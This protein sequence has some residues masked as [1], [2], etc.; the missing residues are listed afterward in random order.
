MAVGTKPNTSPGTSINGHENETVFGSVS[1][2]MKACSNHKVKP[3][4]PALPLSRQGSRRRSGLIG[5][6]FWSS[7][8]VAGY[9]GLIDRGLSYSRKQVQTV[10]KAVVCLEAG[11]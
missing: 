9:R 1:T 10:A 5:I 4:P 7:P 6:M 8:K 11:I 2:P 3:L